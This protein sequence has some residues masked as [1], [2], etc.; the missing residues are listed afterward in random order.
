MIWL[1]DYGNCYVRCFSITAA[2]EQPVE[3]GPCN[4]NFERWYFD[5]EDENCKPF[6]YGG[7]KGNK[8]SFVS[9]QACKYQCKNPSVQKGKLVLTIVI[10]F[11]WGF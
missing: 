3:S 1:I 4:G 5:K 6:R 11:E 10:L 2:C 9:E 8:N 7:C